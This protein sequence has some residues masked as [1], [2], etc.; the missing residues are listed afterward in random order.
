MAQQQEKPR[1]KTGQQNPGKSRQGGQ[2][3]QGQSGQRGQQGHP[4]QQ[5]GDNPRTREEEGEM[6]EDEEE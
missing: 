1:P 5:H 3:G 6:Q 2:G 4:G